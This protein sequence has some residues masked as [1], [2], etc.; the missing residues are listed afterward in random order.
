MFD[1]IK[2]KIQAKKAYESFSDLDDFYNGTP[3][4]SCTSII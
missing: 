2:R 1:K 4:T 3:E